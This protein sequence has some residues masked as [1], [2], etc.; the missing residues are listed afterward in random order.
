MTPFDYLQQALGN[1]SVQE[2]LD[3]AVANA[4][5]AYARARRKKNLEQAARDA[6]IR[7]RVHRSVVEA[8]DAVVALRHGREQARRRRTL[9]VL[10][11]VALTA[12]AVAVLYP[13]LRDQLAGRP[14]TTDQP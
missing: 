1:P 12:T 14:S 3:S 6:A 7:A 11:G 2:H 9:P 4:R 13:G 10:A 5:A 8:R